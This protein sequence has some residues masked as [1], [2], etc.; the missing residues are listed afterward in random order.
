MNVGQV[1]PN[2]NVFVYNQTSCLSKEL[3]SSALKGVLVGG[4]I[5][6]FAGRAIAKGLQKAVEN[7]QQG[8]T[9]VWLFAPD[10]NQLPTP[11]SLGAQGAMR[12]AR[13]GLCA[14]IAAHA[15]DS[16]VHANWDSINSWATS[17][18]SNLAQ[19]WDSILL[20][21]GEWPQRR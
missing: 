11:L 19:L 15:I 20:Q 13:Y 21:L 2:P 17:L 3:V 7:G 16:L 10:T 5:G 14:V 1:A 12:G 4:A 18:E 9:V 8:S 6:A